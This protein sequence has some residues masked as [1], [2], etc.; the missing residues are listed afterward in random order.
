MDGWGVCTKQARRQ[1][2]AMVDVEIDEVPV[3]GCVVEGREQRTI[4]SLSEGTL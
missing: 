3:A 1:F 4:C 2:R